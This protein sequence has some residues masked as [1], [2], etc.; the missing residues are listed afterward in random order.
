MGSAGT[1]GSQQYDPGNSR[2]TIMKTLI[3]SALIALS[4]VAGVAAPASAAD[5]QR[6]VWSSFQTGQGS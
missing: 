1:E 3:L 5:P 4:V 6:G 2:R